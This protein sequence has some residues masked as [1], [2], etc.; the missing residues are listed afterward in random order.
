MVQALKDNRGFRVQIEGHSDS[1]GPDERN[2]TLSE[3]RA[4]AVL[5]YLR[6]HGIA[7][8]RLSSRGFGSSEPSD[9]NKTAAGRES[10]RRVEFVVQFIILDRSAQ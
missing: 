5:R 6:D 3:Q 9:S 2:Q 10:N 7:G 1:S 8:E 4:D